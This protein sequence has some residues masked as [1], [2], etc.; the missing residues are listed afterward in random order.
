MPSAMIG[1]LAVSLTMNTAAFQRGATL[2]EKRA[3]T[4]RGRFAA[5][6]TSVTGLGKA[7]G[8]GIAA[9]VLY[10]VTSSA[11]EMASSL[12]EAA[13]Q[14]GVTV[15]A[16]QELRFA[17]EQTGVGADQIEAAMKRLSRSLGDLQRGK[18][19]AVKA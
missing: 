16:L 4:M 13:E 18:T 17:A 1:N 11:F 7:L 19:A 2:A 3:E 6:T 12:Q 14:T 5:A 8:A 10:R 15:E 9:D